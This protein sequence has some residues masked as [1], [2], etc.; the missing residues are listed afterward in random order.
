MNNNINVGLEG[1]GRLSSGMLAYFTV[2][3]GLNI[4]NV[5]EIAFGIYNTVAVIL[6][7]ANTA[8]PHQK[9]PNMLPA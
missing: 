9:P 1:Y 5:T 7:S 6:F 4:S 2:A 8:V 3:I